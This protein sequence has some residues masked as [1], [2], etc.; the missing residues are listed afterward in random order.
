MY[1]LLCNTRTS[2]TI[3]AMFC[4]RAHHEHVGW[5]SSEF[6]QPFARRR[7]NYIYLRSLS[8]CPSLDCLAGGGGG[9]VSFADREVMFVKH[10]GLR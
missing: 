5:V 4:H 6:A 9:K 2:T 3:L 1:V 10:G 8:F 7:D